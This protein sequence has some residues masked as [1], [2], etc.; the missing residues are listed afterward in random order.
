MNN[1]YYKFIINKIEILSKLE[2]ALLFFLFL[3]IFFLIYSFLN[4]I[5]CSINNKNQIKNLLQNEKK[6]I[7]I[8][9]AYENGK[10]SAKDYKNR[11]IKLNSLFKN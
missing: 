4:F 8:K 5:I 9:Y 1:I 3:L 7:N 11:I 6:L 2:F 10:I